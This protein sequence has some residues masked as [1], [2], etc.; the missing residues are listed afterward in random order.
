M[1]WAGRWSREAVGERHAFHSFGRRSTQVLTHVSTH[2]L[3]SISTQLLDR[4][5]AY[6]SEHRICDLGTKTRQLVFTLF[7]RI[8]QRRT[9]KERVCFRTC[10]TRGRWVNMCVALSLSYQ[11]CKRASRSH[12]KTGFENGRMSLAKPLLL[13]RTDPVEHLQASPLR[14]PKALENTM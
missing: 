12:A 4:T 6:P 3:Q 1:A 7:R 2:I 14:R 11:T 8:P 10:K 13:M 5:L 9:R